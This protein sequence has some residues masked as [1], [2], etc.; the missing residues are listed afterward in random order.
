MR[1]SVILA[2]M[3]FWPLR[4]SKLGSFA[5]IAPSFEMNESISSV[6]IFWGSGAMY[7]S[8][9]TYMGRAGV[10]VYGKSDSG[11]SADARDVHRLRRAEGSA[12]VIVQKDIAGAQI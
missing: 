11:F 4:S 8:T 10:I 9:T 7:G 1:A 12:W 5:A 3:S 2:I 6:S